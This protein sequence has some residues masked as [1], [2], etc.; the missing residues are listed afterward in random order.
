M[1]HTNPKENVMQVET[2]LDFNGRCEEAIEFYKKALGAKVNMLMRFKDHPSPDSCG[3]GPNPAHAEKVMHASLQVGKAS[4]M[5]SDGR[6]TGQTKFE[7]FS[8]SISANSDAEAERIFMALGEGG[9]VTMPLGKTFFASSFGMV[10]DRF[11]VHW[12]L[13]TH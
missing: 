8:L 5:V 12:M 7:G 2:Y 10:K 4:I 6:C 1:G 3:A 13:L 9:T 11:G